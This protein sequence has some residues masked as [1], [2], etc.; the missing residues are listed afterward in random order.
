M[1]VGE[2][3][4]CWAGHQVRQSPGS[5]QWLP[6]AIAR[7]LPEGYNRAVGT[8]PHELGLVEAWESQGPIRSGVPTQLAPEAE[9]AVGFLSAM[10]PKR[11][12]PMI[13]PSALQGTTKLRLSEKGWDV[14]A[15]V[16]TLE[17]GGSIF[18]WSVKITFFR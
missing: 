17:F 5:Q 4:Q 13:T 3:V 12:P 15:T 9:A 16:R 2:R 10:V 6:A 1:N 14:S 7:T 18:W 8:N 11:V